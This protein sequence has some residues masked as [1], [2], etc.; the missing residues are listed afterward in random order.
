MTIELVASGGS[1]GDISDCRVGVTGVDQNR[2]M[3][4]VA[5]WMFGTTPPVVY[6]R[7]PDLSTTEIPALT[8][9]GRVQNTESNLAFYYLPE[10]YVALLAATGNHMYLTYSDS[11]EPGIAQV[12]YAVFRNVKQQAIN[13]GQGKSGYPNDPIASFSPF[14]PGV[15][16]AVN[17]WTSST[18]VTNNV[19]W[20]EASV[21]TTFAAIPAYLVVPPP[22]SLGLSA[23]YFPVSSSGAKSVSW[24]GVP[25]WPSIGTIFLQ[26]GPDPVVAPITANS[27]LLGS[28]F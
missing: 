10:V 21:V 4:V 8:T 2:M 5:N 1:A 22:N 16:V 3:V 24:S 19:L 11:R 12:S 7:P 18:S 17:A 6:V 9:Y 28:N 20:T 13:A 25:A 14:A 23:G 27:M 15:G 26:Q